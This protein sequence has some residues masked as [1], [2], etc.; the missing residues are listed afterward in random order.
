MSF[1][2]VDEMRIDALLAEMT[3]E[4]KV[5]L[6]HAWSKFSVAGAP[7]LGIPEL[8]MSDGPHGVREELMRDSWMTANRDDDYVTYLPTGTALAATWNRAMAGLHGSIL[9][10]EARGRGKDV[11]L[12]PGVNIMRTP[13]CGRNFEYLGEDPFLAAELVVPEI[14]GIQAHDVAACVKHFALN[15]QE[16][17]RMRVDVEVDDR[18]LREIYLPA[19]EAAVCR[20]QVLTVMGAYNR[21][22]GEH[23]CH[24][25]L[26]LQEILKGQWG[27]RGLVVSDWNGTHDT[28]QAARNG[29]D[30]EMGTSVASY[31]QYYLA[32]PFLE[33]LRQGRYDVALVDD[34]VRRVLR[35]MMAAGLFDP[36]RRKGA[37]ATEEHFRGARRIAEE[38]MVL[39]KN[40]GV[41]P[42]D[43]ATIRT[44]AVIG[45]NA[46]V[47]H[48]Q[49]GGSSGV[50]TAREITPLEGLRELLGDGVAI[51]YVRGYPAEATAH[52]LIPNQCLAAV[53]GSGTGGWTF[54]VFDNT[55]LAGPARQTGSMQTVDLSWPAGRMPFGLATGRTS[56]RLTATV[57]LPEDGLYE[58]AFTGADQFT[59][60]VDGQKKVALWE[61]GEGSLTETV[62]LEG[63]RGDRHTIEI[64]FVPLNGLAG[65]FRVAWLTPSSDR[66][67]CGDPFAEAVAA[68]READAVIFV[69][70]LNHRDDAEGR[71]RKD[72]KLPYDQDRLIEAL[73]AAN[74]KL[75]V[76]LVGGSPV[77]MPWAD[78]VP[79]I[80]QA[81][82]A[83]SEGGRVLADVA[84]GRVNPSGKLPCTFPKRLA[85]TPAATVGQYQ[86]G[87]CRYNEGLFVG[88]RWYDRR[89]IEPLFPFGHGLSYTTFQ[90]GPL[91]VRP[92]RGDVAAEAELTVRNAGTRAGAEVVQLYVGRAAPGRVERPVRELKGFEKVFLEPGQQATVRFRLSR[93]DVS[94][95]D[96]EAGAWATE[97][98]DYVLSVG[99]SSRDLRQQAHFVLD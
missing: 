5:S 65:A 76:F 47:R 62:A 3:L 82:Y 79:A 44:L 14:E 25:R 67:A 9:G 93:R 38:A 23:C 68:A 49:G 88:Y 89:G 54:E 92:G 33:G 52:E 32:G 45:W 84:F 74:K 10:E 70:G 43:A 75:A 81:W 30:V 73:A 20:A 39:L 37:Y 64:H 24:N 86:A 40:D 35:V 17:D 50:K 4:E 46:T 21:F 95:W 29:L 26:L 96:A 34:K 97:P 16:R 83:G 59:V 56:L 90:Y 99:S 11:I 61:F 51:R 55:A 85:D 94:F 42:F 27:F 77:E 57:T 13:L 41:L 6:C 53:D 8:V 71:D 12:G 80:V 60:F 72:L 48:A 69:G 2:R 87:S 7:R 31:D 63:R 58:L 1:A 22:R 78:R 18:A 66:S 91:V 15:N 19:F 36:A 98:G 28:D